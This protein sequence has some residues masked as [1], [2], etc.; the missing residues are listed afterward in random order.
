ME[1]RV[2]AQCA[3]VCF[4]LITSSDIE[5]HFREK[6]EKEY[7]IQFSLGKWIRSFIFRFFTSLY[8]TSFEHK[9][10]YWKRDDFRLRKCK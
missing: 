7:E 6:S 1:T 3:R 9:N 8:I 5:I 10:L 4:S 2:C